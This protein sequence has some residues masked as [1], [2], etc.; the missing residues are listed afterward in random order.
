MSNQFNDLAGKTL[1]VRPRKGSERPP[2]TSTPRTR[3]GSIRPNPA[4][5]TPA[6]RS[7]TPLRA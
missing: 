6:T 3:A 2:A 4:W 5:R 7:K 1:R